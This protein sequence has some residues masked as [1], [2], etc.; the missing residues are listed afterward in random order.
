M[1]LDSCREKAKQSFGVPLEMQTVSTLA[2]DLYS[3]HLSP[4]R[5]A[6]RTASTISQVLTF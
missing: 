3:M 4:M 6:F 5:A 2:R 1:L